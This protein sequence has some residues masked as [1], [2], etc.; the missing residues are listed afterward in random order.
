MPSLNWIGKEKVMT[1][2]LDVPFHT[3][4]HKYGF[5][6]TNLD[7]K[8]YTGS[9]NIIIHGDNLIGLKA[10][11]PKYVGT[12]KCIYIDPPYNTGN[13][14][15][16][17]NDNVNDPRIRKWLGE[18]VGPEGEDLSRDDKWLCMMY[19]RLVLLRQLLAD[20]GAIFI[21]IDD[22]EVAALKFLCDEIF[23]AHNFIGQWMWYKSATPPNL[24]LKIKKNIEYVLCYEKHKTKNKYKGVQ[25]VSP[26]DDPLITASNPISTLTFK[27]G[28]LHF[29]GKDCVY[30]PGT[31]G[32][33][34]NPTV[35]LNELVFKDGLNVTTVSMTNHWRWQQSFLEKEIKSGN[36]INCSK[37]LVLSHKKVNYDPEVP[38]NF[39]DFKVGVNTTEEAGKFLTRLFGK[40]V[41]DFPKDVS[42]IE[43]LINFLCDKDAI[44]LDSFAGSGTTAHAVLDLNNQDGGNRKFILIEL[45]DYAEDITAER[46]RKVSIG[47]PEAGITG[48]GG[49][50]DFYELDEP[51]F[52]S[53]NYLNESVSEEKIREFIFYSETK[54]PLIR[55][56]KEGEFILDTYDNVGY[57]FFYNKDKTTT[58]SLD[59]L[60]IVTEKAESYIIYAD[61]CNLSESY[62]TKHNIVFKKIPRDIIHY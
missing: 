38:P 21:S 27:P 49:S 55:P 32:T 15:W 34:K 59:T 2:H 45:C 39:I 41:F 40:K 48:L 9:G 31:Y 3:L 30:V 26:S 22:N 53:H 56:H 13:E 57:Y 8:S 51:L 50:F 19:P 60:S 6:S 11:L 17:Y 14:K 25:K 36:R 52:D 62:M 54:R 43:Y 18:I 47:V 28:E 5:R 12:I 4:K 29:K 35:L 16:I 23:G 42:L 24:S 58:L 1:H 33:S 10:L 37:A 46:V 7:D 44:I 61:L 20:D